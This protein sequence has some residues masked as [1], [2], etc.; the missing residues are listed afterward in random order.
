MPISSLFCVRA[1]DVS[2]IECF[3]DW[4]S[5]VGAADVPPAQLRLAKLRLL[6]TIGLV[7][8]ARNH[9]VAASLG[10]FL[11]GRPTGP[12][13]I[14]G[15]QNRVPAEAAA[16]IN[17]VLAHA[18]DFDDT[19]PESVVHP[20]SIVVPAAVAMAEQT[21]SSLA[22][23]A[24]AIAIGYELA[25]RLGAAAGRGFHARGFHATSVVGPIAA[26]AA[27]GHLLKLGA[28]PM[29]DALGLATS[30]SGGLLAFLADGAW[31]KW[32]HTGWSAQA[33]VQ[34]ASLADAGFRGPRDALEH[35]YG[36]YGAFLGAPLA[37]PGA[38]V[39]E[40][41]AVWRGEE[42]EPKR[43]PCAHVI[44]PYLDGILALRAK[45]GIRGEDVDRVA[46]RIAAWAEPIVA[47]PRGRKIAPE[48]DLDAIA[49]L[50][51]L[52]AAALVDG[53]VD[54]ETLEQRS[55]RRTELRSLAARVIHEVDAEF[56]DGFQ[57]AV[58]IDLTG[59]GRF[60]QT[61]RSVRDPEAILP[62]LRANLD[63]TAPKL[64]VANL[65]EIVLGDDDMDIDAVVSI[66]NSFDDTS[67]G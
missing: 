47:M 50:P 38:L 33:G 36:L 28:Q 18:R 7:Y 27:A 17:G 57:G 62:K 26:A 43:Y 14:F 45:H 20:G 39:A 46:C 30:A 42:A 31:S 6:D 19:F 24:V 8:A 22:E 15:R 16:L 59:G 55:L 60:G 29:A 10:R 9:P 40:I 37:D 65:I 53:K 48:T 13:T 64:D 1:T 67:C 44:Q 21:Q 58:E 25:A 5:G 35:H 52:I 51:F 56:E 4:A 3:A 12:S 32:L 63:V 2:A 49:S 34:A 23:T 11:E 66:A 61:V 41:G 54:L